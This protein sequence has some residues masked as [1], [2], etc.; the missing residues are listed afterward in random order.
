MSKIVGLVF[1]ID[2]RTPEWIFLQQDRCLCDICLCATAWAA[3]H[4]DNRRR[5]PK[6]GLTATRGNWTPKLLSL[7]T[8]TG[9]VAS[10]L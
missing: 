4:M 10:L 7:F 5:I 3:K 6:Q 9:A 2:C 8:T 1:E